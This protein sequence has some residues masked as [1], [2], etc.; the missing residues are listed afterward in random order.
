MDI[1]DKL[2]RLKSSIKSGNPELIDHALEEI[3]NKGDDTYISPLIEFLHQTTNKEIKEKV[4]GLFVDLKHEESVDILINAMENENDLDVLERLLAACW[5][6][7]LNYS[8]HLPYFVQLIIDQE[9]QIAFEAFTVIE[10][11]YGKIDGDIESMLLGK[12]EKSIPSADE[13]KQYLLK[14]LLEIIPHIP[15]DQDPVDF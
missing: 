9:F 4:Y 2:S 11:M 12:I 8:K 10:N 3:K 1:L 6:N 5:Q 14:G 15:I 7:G 13:K